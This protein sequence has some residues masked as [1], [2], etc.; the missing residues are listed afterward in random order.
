MRRDSQL[1]YRLYSDFME[2]Y[3]KVLPHCYTQEQC[4]E[5][6][7][8][9]PAPRFYITPRQCYNVLLGMH[10]DKEEFLARQQLV[11]RRL[12][13]DIYDTTLRLSGRWRYQ[14]MSLSQISE[15]VVVQPA[16]SFYVERRTMEKIYSFMKA[17]GFK[18]Y[19]D[20]NDFFKR[21]YKRRKDGRTEFE[22]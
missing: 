18:R 15:F 1:Q 12:Y 10:H 2:A 9:Y 6:L 20:W 4:W 3:R 17:G 5:K 13:E 16:K 21:H 11:K 19:T 14:G 7:N 8:H 22:P